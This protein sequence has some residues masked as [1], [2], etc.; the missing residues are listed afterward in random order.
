VTEEVEKVFS[1][2]VKTSKVEGG[3]RG[4]GS[5]GGGTSGGKNYSDLPQ[6]AKETCERQATR[7]VGKG[8]AFETAEAWR[9]HYAKT[10]FEEA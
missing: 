10:Y 3:S 8:R 1:P 4:S 9:K 5:G 6:D 2:G 7:L